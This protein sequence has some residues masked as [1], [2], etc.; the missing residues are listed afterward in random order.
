ML[1]TQQIINT[2]GIHNQD[3]T[4]KTKLRMQLPI[5]KIGM[6]INTIKV[7]IIPRNK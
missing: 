6:P 3:V 7:A 1:K 4:A 5:T 2:N